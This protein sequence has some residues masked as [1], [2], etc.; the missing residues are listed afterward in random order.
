MHP[1]NSAERTSSS[2]SCSS[3]GPSQQPQ[4]QFQDILPFRQSPRLTVVTSFA[5]SAPSSNGTYSQ[6]GSDHYSY[7]SGSTPGSHT[8]KSSASPPMNP[9]YSTAA[10]K[11]QR[12]WLRIRQQPR[13]GRACSNGRDR[14]AVDPPPVLQLQISDF[15][16]N[17][18]ADIE[19]M[20]DQSFIVHCL[21]CT[22]SGPAQ[23]ISVV[24]CQDDSS[25][26]QKAE[27]QINGNLDASPFFC[28][29]DPDPHTAPPHPSSQ[30]YYPAQTIPP[31]HASARNLPATFFYFADLSIRRAGVY[32]LEFQLMRLKMD[33]T[34]LPILHS[35]LSEPFNVVN[36]K[37]FDHVQPST[38]LVRGLVASGA[39]F[40]LKLKQGSRA[41]RSPDE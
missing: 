22:A 18:P 35:V 37:D 41:Q 21:L 16:P 10:A 8:P 27:K 4:R 11:K 38:P 7:I 28:D 25:S 26:G 14:R 24:M 31:S 15:D 40:P 29:E 12:Y 1:R 36:A 19:D 34:P 30:L 17:S 23:D 5:A 6:A 9:S 39:G 20:Q 33:G 13:A 2:G 32:R 3:P